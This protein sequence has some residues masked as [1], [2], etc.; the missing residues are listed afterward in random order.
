MKNL[1]LTI[2]AGAFLTSAACSGEADTPV[3]TIGE[4]EA[5]A[6]H[7]II[8]FSVSE[9]NLDAFLDIM[10]NINSLMASEEGFISAQVY[11][12]NNDPLAFTLIEAW[13]TQ[14]AHETHFEHI[15]TSGDWAGILAML[16]KEPEMS[17]NTQL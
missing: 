15:N 10:T 4:N 12:S 7:L 8:R 5:T 11:R 1:L 9:E 16:T 14:A 2:L 6:T 13:K 3:K 17:Y